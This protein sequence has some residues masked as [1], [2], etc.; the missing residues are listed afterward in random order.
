VPLPR[1]YLDGLPAAQRELLER[2]NRSGLLALRDYLADGEAIAFLGAGA[3]APLYPLWT[4]VICELVGRAS[5]ELSTQAATTCRALAATHSEAVVELLRNKFGAAEYRKVLREVFEP[6]R[7]PKSKRTWT[8][9]HELVARCAFKAVVTTNYDPGIVD[10]R[11]HVRPHPSSTGFVTWAD[12]EAMDLWR[13]GD[14]FGG[15]EL[16][17]LYAHGHHHRPEDVVLAT[18][19]YRRAYNGKLAGVLNRLIDSGHL[20]WIGFSFADQRIAAV[21]RDVAGG[22]GSRAEPG[23][24]ERH[25]ALM[26]WAPVDA[27]GSGTGSHDPDVLAELAKIAYGCRLVLYP[28]SDGDHSALQVLLGEFT[29][30]RF[31][32]IPDLNAITVADVASRTHAASPIEAAASE[33]GTAPER[34]ADDRQADGTTSDAS[35]TRRAGPRQG[36]ESRLAVRWVHGGTPVDHFTGRA[37]EL[38]RLDRW[39]AEARV[40][41]VGVTAKGGGGKTALVTEWLTHRTRPAG[42]GA[43]RPVRGLF[44]WSFS[45]NRS[46]EAWAQS[47]LAWAEAE[48]GLRIGP[49]SFAAQVLDLAR[50]APL[51]LVLDGLEALQEGP[52]GSQYGRLLDGVLREVLT[53]WCRIDHPGLALLTSRFPF[54]DIEGYDGT[55]ARMLDVLPLTPE[56]GAAL[57]AASGA[58]WLNDADRRDLADAVDGHPM[59]VT[60]LG[61]ALSEAAGTDVDALRDSLIQAGRTEARVAKALAVYANWLSIA[62]RHLAAIV[63]LFQRPVPA[64]TVLTIGTSTTLGAPLVGWTE[65]AVQAAACQR[66]AGRLTWHPDRTVSAHPLIRYAFRRFALTGAKLASD[67]FLADLPR[68]AV[69][70]RDDAL[71]VVEMIEL[72]LDADQWDAAHDLYQSRTNHGEVWLTMPAAQLGQRAATAFVATP[73]RRRTCRTRLSVL[74]LGFYL[75]EV[76][77]FGTITG[78]LATAQDYLNEAERI[79]RAQ[80]EGI[81]LA[82]DLGNLSYYHRLLGNTER[83]HLATEAITLA[84]KAIDPAT[85]TPE[86]QQLL[87]SHAHLGAAL[88]LAGDTDGAQAQFTTADLIWFTNDPDGDHLFSLWGVWWGEFLARTGRT[89]PAR[90]LTERNRQISEREASNDDVARCDRLLGRLDLAAGHL[91]PAGKRLH[92]AARTFQHGDYLVEWTATLPD[93]AE[94]TRR[95]GDLGGAEDLC[96]QAIDAA[97]PRGLVPTHARALAT[98]ATVRADRY[99]TDPDPGHLACARDDANHALRLATSTRH[100]PWAALD[101]LA[102]QAHIDATEGR[103]HGWQARADALRATLAPLG[104]DPDPLAT[105]ERQATEQKK[106]EKRRHRRTR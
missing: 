63:S 104:L 78:D 69:T 74:D 43:R 85:D 18:T 24:M 30:P 76:G 6:R 99:P 94:Y 49:G 77:L 21:I 57:M 102:A 17:V 55:A 97:G 86:H 40:R 61:D 1:R 103:N 29:D 7:H 32:P 48:F 53:R 51:L 39:A 33:G 26:P 72:L 8:V 46:A 87:I 50:A 79:H 67:I 34:T 41:L 92:A 10:A 16:P 66:L 84:A 89:R 38:G 44:A 19:E 23:G 35:R 98:R 91:K 25:V 75:H 12:E 54:A 73:D 101:A 93:L 100:L 68:K 70:N 14:V 83:T 5:P 31:P 3:S 80:N 96:T 20:V 52:A 47:L 4:G 36:P 27:V 37:D 95:T 22:W 59:I 105:V 42:P 90:R 65:A 88:D 71:R 28:A 56:E 62:D 64:A 2:V 11:M 60:V 81:N 13:T 45:E 58:G 106:Q 82:E 15:E 9:T